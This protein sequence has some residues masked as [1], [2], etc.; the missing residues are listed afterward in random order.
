MSNQNISSSVPYV[1]KTNG[2][3]TVYVRGECMTV[4]KDHSNYSKVVDAL[5][6]GNATA[7]EIDGLINEVKNKLVDY[8]KGSDVTIKDGQVYYLGYV[9]NNSLSRRILTMMAEGFKFDHMVAFLSNLLKNPSNRALNELYTFLE[10][11]GL[12][13]TDDGHFIAYKA[14]KADYFDIYTGKTYKN[15]V[16]STIEMPRVMV[17]ERYEHDCSIGLHCGAHIS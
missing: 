4:A 8:T 5:K 16:G 2:D 15:T 11:S 10:N 14:V 13:I 17:D 7:S 12:P 9:I 1:I 6:R 3:I